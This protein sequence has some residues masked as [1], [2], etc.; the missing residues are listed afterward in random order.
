MV[1]KAISIGSSTL[2]Y[3]QNSVLH[4]ADVFVRST[5]RDW[6]AS[7]IPGII[8]FLGSLTYLSFEGIIFNSTIT[9]LYMTLYIYFFN[10]WTQYTSVDEDRINKP[11]RPIP[12][13]ITTTAGAKRRGMVLTA[14]WFG[15][16]VYRPD[17]IVETWILVVATI[18]LG[19][20]GFGRHWF[21]KNTICMTVMTWGL[22][23][24]LRKL[25]GASP[26]NTSNHVFS[27][28]LWS[29]F[30]L[31]AQD[32][33]DIDGDM[34]TGRWTL[35]IA[36]GDGNAR[37][38]FAFFCMPLGYMSLWYTGMA[39]LAPWTLAGLHALVSF[40]FMT[41]RN[42]PADHASYMWICKIFCIMCGLSSLEAAKLISSDRP[43]E[44][45]VPCL[46]L[47]RD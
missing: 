3:I 26:P 12:A 14:L 45:A 4:E 30:V 32:F 7:V 10:T 28:S 46:L 42:K 22:L 2:S 27:L 39:Q 38:L 1:A 44:V 31:Y 34:E 35:P 19:L 6:L 8:F 17:L 16:A 21:V 33:R 15:F 47:D 41:L 13:G 23:S 20:S 29:G 36:L 9:V 37:L 25:M 43:L 18:T 5:W 11:D 24:S 40:R